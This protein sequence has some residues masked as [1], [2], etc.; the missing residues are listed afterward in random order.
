[1]NFFENFTADQRVQLGTGHAFD[2]PAFPDS[3]G[4]SDQ[5]QT[6]AAAMWSHVSEYVPQVNAIKA[7]QRYSDFGRAE[8]IE[9]IAETAHRRILGAWHNLNNFEQTID[10]L[11]RTLVGVPSIDPSNFMA[12]L[13]DREIREWWERQNAAT[14]AEQMR[15]M[16][17]GGQSERIALAVLRSPI[18]HGDTEK[19]TFRAMWEDSRRAANPVEAERIAL[20]RKAVEWVERNLH[21]A[22]TVVKAVSGWDKDRILKHALTDQG[23]TFKPYASKLG[24]SKSDIAQ[25]ELRMRNRR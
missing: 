20:G 17:E 10:L 7:D 12:Q 4:S 8:K 23:G 15:L 14:R 16:A 2:I 25:A 11:E 3:T 6:V 22:N 1:M 24:F 5:A 19:A 13:E 18:P 21:Y 9:P